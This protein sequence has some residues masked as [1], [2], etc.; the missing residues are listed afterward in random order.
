ME[1]IIKDM[2]YNWNRCM[3]FEIWM[4]KSKGVVSV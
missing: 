1:E 4:Q 2:S 3:K